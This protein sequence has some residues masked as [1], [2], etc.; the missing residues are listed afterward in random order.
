M[1]WY[2]QHK[3]LLYPYCIHKESKPLIVLLLKALYA[4]SVKTNP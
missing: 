2:T 1:L 3:I 4:V